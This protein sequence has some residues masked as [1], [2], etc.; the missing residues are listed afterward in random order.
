MRLHVGSD[1]G[2]VTLRLALVAYA[3]EQG[4]TIASELGP[5]DATDSVDYPDI[6]HPVCAKV[7]ADPGSFGLLVCGTGQGIAMAANALSG[8]R[9]GVMSDVFSARMVRAH[10]DANVLCMGGRVVGVGLACEIFDAFAAT[11][12]EG[13]R[14]TRR[15]GKIDPAQS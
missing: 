2:G 15:V 7:L 8:I 5:A 3:A 10:N 4:H 1:H 6:A 14:H 11:A 9:A 12:F 13:G